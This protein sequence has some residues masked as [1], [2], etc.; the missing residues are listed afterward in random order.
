[1]IFTSIGAFDEALDALQKLSN[2][3]Y[4]N[5]LNSEKLA[6]VGVAINLGVSFEKLDLYYYL[7]T[8][9]LGTNNYSSQGVYAVLIECAYELR[10]E[11]EQ[12]S[13]DG[14]TVHS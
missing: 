2:N 8:K 7:V 10:M 14:E 1:M 5:E 6:I 11:K 9:R 4:I 12:P 13:A 3:T